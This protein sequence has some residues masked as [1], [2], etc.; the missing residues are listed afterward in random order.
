MGF[1][2][3]CCLFCRS[4]NL[5][6]DHSLGINIH[7]VYI[8]RV[9]ISR[10]SLAVRVNATATG[11]ISRVGPLSPFTR[12]RTRAATTA[13]NITFR[14]AKRANGV[15]TMK[16]GDKRTVYIHNTRFPR[17]P[18]T[19]RVGVGKGNS[20]RVRVSDPSNPLL[21]ALAFSASA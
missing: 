16:G 8:R 17:S 3:G 14:P 2:K 12:R 1:R 13:H 18:R 5:R 10:G 7:D 20:V 11:N 4:L 19:V 15:S 9:R 21:S 6:S